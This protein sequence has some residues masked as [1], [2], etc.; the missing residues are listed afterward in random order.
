MS[1]N[2]MIPKIFIPSGSPTSP[3]TLA[4]LSRERKNSPDWPKPQ[5]TQVIPVM[6]VM[7]RELPLHIMETFYSRMGREAS[8][9]PEGC[10]ILLET[11]HCVQN[12][13]TVHELIVNR[14]GVWVREA[15][16]LPLDDPSIHWDVIF[17]M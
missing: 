4:P 10:R 2:I 9:Y 5:V 17:Q 15:V 16:R 13:F 6:P 14:G 3:V 8:P 11:R 12:S 7:T 1:E